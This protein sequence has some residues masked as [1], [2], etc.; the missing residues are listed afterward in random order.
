VIADF[1]LIVGPWLAGSV[2][3]ALLLIR[4]RTGREA[5]LRPAPSNVRVLPAPIDF[6]AEVQQ[7]LAVSDPVC[8]RRLRL[9]DVGGGPNVPR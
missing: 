2:F 1:L 6:E 8:L 4:L 3:V 9:H 7:A 5:P